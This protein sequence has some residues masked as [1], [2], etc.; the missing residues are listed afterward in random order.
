MEKRDEIPS[1]QVQEHSA[2]TDDLEQIFA[3]NGLARDGKD[4][5]LWQELMEWKRTKY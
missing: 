5:L 2:V 4:S 1:E 3:N